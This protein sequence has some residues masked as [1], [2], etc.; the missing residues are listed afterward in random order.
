M[1]YGHDLQKK[2]FQKCIDRYI[3]LLNFYNW[4]FKIDHIY[5]LFNEKSVYRVV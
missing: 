4:F 3:Y 1:T 5:C 2:K